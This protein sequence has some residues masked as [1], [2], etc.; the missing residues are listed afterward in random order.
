VCNPRTVEVTGPTITECSTRPRGSRVRT[1]TGQRLSSSANQIS[2]R[3]TTG[4][5]TSGR[6]TL[7]PSQCRPQ[8]APIGEDATERDLLIG[9]GHGAVGLDVVA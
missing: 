7:R 1:K 9:G 8:V 6:A 5:V 3:R 2:P 4:G